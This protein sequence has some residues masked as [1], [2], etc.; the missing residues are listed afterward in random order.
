V[1][2]LDEMALSLSWW[3]GSQWDEATCSLYVR[4]TDQNRLSVPVCHLSRFALFGKPYKIYLPVM[5]R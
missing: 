5:T 2:G 4:W 1:T 3:Q